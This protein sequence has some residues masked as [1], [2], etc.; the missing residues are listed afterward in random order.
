MNAQAADLG[1]HV[2]RVC[3]YCSAGCR[4]VLLRPDAVQA[5]RDE[6][7]SGR[8]RDWT[9]LL[10][11][12]TEE[13]YAHLVGVSQGSA[14]QLAFGLD[15]LT[16]RQEAYVRHRASVDFV[17]YN[18]VGAIARYSPSR[19]SSS[20]T[21]RTTRLSSSE[22]PSRRRSSTRWLPLLRLPATSSDEK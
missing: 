22:T 21:T 9:V 20:P 4:C 5:R 17:V 14:A 16:A 8:A 19:S 3:E 10:G 7:V 1:V 18:R 11:V 13:K 15:A 2:W 6:Q 12:L